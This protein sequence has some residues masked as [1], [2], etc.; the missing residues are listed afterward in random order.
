MELI[1]SATK[2]VKF[3]D[4]KAKRSFIIP[5]NL[6]LP[7]VEILNYGE[8]LTH[9][10]AVMA[11][12]VLALKDGTEYRVKHDDFGPI[13]ENLQSYEASAVASKPATDWLDIASRF[14]EIASTFASMV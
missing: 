8:H 9:Q 6:F 2:S 13:I 5:L 7:S 1:E 11:W 14:S 10:D 3:Y 4:P 12:N